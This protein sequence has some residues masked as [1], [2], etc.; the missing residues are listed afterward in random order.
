MNVYLLTN[1]TTGKRYVGMTIHKAEKRFRQHCSLARKNPKTL[2]H[3]AINKY[4]SKC[5]SI[6]LLESGF[7]TLQEMANAEIR[8]IQKLNPE[9]NMAVGGFGGDTSESPNFTKYIQSRDIAGEK[10]PRFG[11]KHTDFSK[12]AISAAKAGVPLSAEHKLSAIATLRANPPSSDAIKR[13][14]EKKAKTYKITTPTG[15]TF[16]VKNLTKFLHGA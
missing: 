7:T 3:R 1:N 6:L 16:I 14:A 12:S 8:Y 13:R 4:G 9:L 2:L 10:H 5:W 11:K 15:D